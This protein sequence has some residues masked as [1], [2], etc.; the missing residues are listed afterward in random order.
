MV[1]EISVICLFLVSHL[2]H[3]LT[4]ATYE[5]RVWLTRA[6]LTPS[7]FLIL[8]RSSFTSLLPEGEFFFH[9]LHVSLD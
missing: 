6:R 2:N 4:R 3:E 7:C 8:Q 1:S 5:L 9:F